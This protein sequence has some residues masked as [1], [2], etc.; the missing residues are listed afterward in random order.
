MIFPSPKVPREMGIKAYD[1][2]YFSR[3]TNRILCLKIRVGGMKKDDTA[4]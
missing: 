1:D 4:A 2:S 3:R